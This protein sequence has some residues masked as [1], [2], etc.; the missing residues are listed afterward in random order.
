MEGLFNSIHSFLIS[1]WGLFLAFIELFINLVPFL[2]F[3]LIMYL[4]GYKS[5]KMFLLK[6]DED[7]KPNEGRFSWPYLL[8]ACVFLYPG[9]LMITE[10][11]D[12][13][14]YI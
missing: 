10:T 7:G 1:L 8:F 5:L 6:K 12:Y 11:I 2:I 13:F 9:Y 3:L 14:K 4:F